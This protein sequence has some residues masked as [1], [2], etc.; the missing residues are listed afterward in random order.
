MSRIVPAVLPTSHKNFDDTLAL[1][2][3]IPNVSRIQ[4]DVVDGHFAAPASWP[5]TAVHE[6]RDMVA[7]GDMLPSLERIAYEVDLMCLDPDRAAE[8]WVALGASRLTVHAESTTDLP[9]LLTTMRKHYGC[10]LISCDL[11]SIGVAL[12]IETDLLLVE[13][14]LDKVDYVQFMGIARIGRQGELFDRRVVDKVRSFHTRHPKID[15]QIDGGVSL[16]NAHEL[17]TLDVAALIAGSSILRSAD[18][19]AAYEKLEETFNDL[20]KGHRV[21]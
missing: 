12:N 18:P 21:Y 5:Y 19:R 11:V 14:H 9:R 3:L 15:V 4:I 7:R 8:A 1:L 13:P 10:D 16:I 2:S 20:P 17:A 6:L